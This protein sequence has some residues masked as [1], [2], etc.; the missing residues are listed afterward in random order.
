VRLTFERKPFKV[1]LIDG[2]SKVLINAF[3]IQLSQEVQAILTQ[4]ELKIVTLNIKVISSY[5]K[6]KVSICNS[7]ILTHYNK[8]KT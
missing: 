8:E 6:S 4:I 2:Y 3:Y 1:L 7:H 5:S